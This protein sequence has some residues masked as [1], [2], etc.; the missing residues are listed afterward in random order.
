MTTLADKLKQKLEP[1]NAV[2]VTVTD[3]SHHHAGHAGNPDGKGQTHFTVSVVAEAFAGQSRLAR[4]RM[5][6]DLV[7]P[8]WAETTLH[9]LVIKT[10]TPAEAE[11]RG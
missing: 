4:Q 6:M 7:Q 8:L 11:I 3:D 2:S 1:L 5:V 10:A 9:A